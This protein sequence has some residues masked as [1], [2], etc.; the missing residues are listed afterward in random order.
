MESAFAAFHLNPFDSDDS[1]PQALDAAASSSFVATPRP[2][3][4]V[5]GFESFGRPLPKAMAKSKAATS[6]P[7]SRI[8]YYKTI[9]KAWSKV[10]ALR[11]GDQLDPT[12]LDANVR[13][14]DLPKL[15]KNR[16]T[17]GGLVRESWREVGH[18]GSRRRG[19][20]T[21]SNH[22][23]TMSA[24]PETNSNLKWLLRQT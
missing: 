22:E 10:V 15:H 13:A 18:G 9:I 8:H 1:Q 4:I 2:P 20:I 17:A 21:H 16:W 11:A 6:S 19:D 23:V 24:P 5:R 3:D 14:S 12:V 7:D